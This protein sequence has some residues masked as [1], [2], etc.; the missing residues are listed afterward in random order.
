MS[1]AGLV[2]QEA[3]AAALLIAA[4]DPPDGGRIT[5]DPGSHGTDGFPTGNGQHDA[6]MLDLE[7]RQVPGTGHS[8]KDREILGSDGQR[9]RFASTH[10]RFSAVATGLNLPEYRGP[11]FLALLV[12]RYTRNHE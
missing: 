5:F 4:T 6:R 12:S 9:A 1:H 2:L 3:L 11:E 7:P 8:L 10:G